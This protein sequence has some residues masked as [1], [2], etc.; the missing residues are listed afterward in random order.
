MQIV[1]FKFSTVLA[2]IKEFDFA[3]SVIDP[4]GIDENSSYILCS[5][6]NKIERGLYY[7]TDEYKHEAESIYNSLILVNYIPE[8]KDSNIY[9]KVSNP[10]LAHYKVSASIEKKVPAGIHPTAIISPDAQIAA[11]AHIG[12]YCIIG[13]CIIEDDVQL[14][15]HI[16]VNDNVLIKKNTVIEANSLIGARG[17]AWIWDEN[18]V[19][20]MQPQLGGVIIEEDCLLGSD[21]SIVRG[22]LS[23]DTIVG[24]GTVMAHGTKIGHG[25]KIG[26]YVHL[27]N[28]VSLAG[29]AHIGDRVFLGSAC[30]IAPSVYVAEGCIVGAGSVVTK[31]VHETH[32]AIAGVPGKVIKKDNFEYKPKGA[33]KPFKNI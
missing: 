20:I 17:M 29:N 16:T 14:L 24:K 3:C 22:S 9:I 32:A 1:E 6:K 8:Q 31:S 27:A 4:S 12:P 10:Q 26:K 23:E 13:N 5:S 18:G 2:L 28:N 11:T 15:G 25:S 30:T 33:P 19:R 7:L 21:I